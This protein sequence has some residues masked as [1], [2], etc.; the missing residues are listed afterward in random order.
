[1]KN[2]K[3]KKLLMLGTSYLSSE[4][5]RYAKSLGIYTIV[6]DYLDPQDSV[7]KTISDEYWMINTNE[8]DLLEQ[9]CREENI[10]I[11]TCGIS[12]FNLEVSMELCKRLGLGTYCTPEAWHYSRDKRDFKDLCKKLGGPVAKDYYLSDK[13]T[14]A[15]I[16]AVELPVMVKPVDMSGNRGISY[17]YTKEDLIKGYKYARSLSKNSKIIIERMLHGREWWAGYAIADGH[18]SLMSLNGMYS[19]PGEPANCYTITSTVTDK[20]T[21]FTKEINPKIEDILKAVGCKEG[22]AWVQLMLDEDGEFYIIEM[23][24]RLTGEMIFMPLKH[25][26][27][28]DTVKWLFDSSLGIKH[29]KDQL[30]TPQTHAFKGTSTGMALWTNKSGKITSI[31]GWDEILKIPGVFAETLHKVGDELA[32]YRPF[33][34]VTFATDDFDSMEEM[35]KQINNNL[36]VYN[37]NNE[38]MLIKYT[39][40]DFLRSLYEKGLAE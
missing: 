5:V 30:P 32:L 38:D 12:E 40:F 31:D 35:I 15:E 24:Y 14:D 23:G 4:I 9:K 3:G 1:M 21:K 37:E 2:L 18:I 34:Y 29:T 7:A 27:G 19:Q 17:C 20:I 13:L 36:H 22:F 25:T 33:G 28:F 10:T 8:V 16:D 11:V 26:I 6:T 39:D